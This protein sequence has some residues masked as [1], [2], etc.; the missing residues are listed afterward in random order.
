MNKTPADCREAGK[1]SPGSA[2][3]PPLVKG[4]K[5]ERAA[6]NFCR[7]KTVGNHGRRVNEQL[8]GN[9]EQCKA[10]QR[11]LGEVRS[12]KASEVV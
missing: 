4:G 2:E 3:P 7:G 5:G 12:S 9:K 8:T 6:R 1:Q 10:K 11:D